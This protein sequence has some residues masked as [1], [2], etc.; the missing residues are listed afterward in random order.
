MGNGGMAAA[1]GGEKGERERKKENTKRNTTR[2][3]YTGSTAG[4]RHQLAQISANTGRRPKNRTPNT[5]H[6]TR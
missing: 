2:D 4:Y 1:G 5:R 3:I 6:K